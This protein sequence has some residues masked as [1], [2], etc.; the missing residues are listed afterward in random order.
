MLLSACSVF[1]TQT[2]T[3]Q[4]VKTL[5][6]IIV[7]Y[8]EPNRIQFSGKGAGAGMAL[9][10]TMGPMGMA[11][12]VAIDEGIAKDI[13]TVINQTGFS[14][15]TQLQQNL[16]QAGFNIAESNTPDAPKLHIKGYGFKSQPKDGEDYAIA[17][18][19]AELT[20]RDGSVKTL[21]YQGDIN[22]P[23]QAALLGQLKRDGEVSSY[24]FK[25]TIQ[26]L[27]KDVLQ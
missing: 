1:N 16:Q 11:I 27:I 3:E 26:L 17:W 19:K 21:E 14:V 18:I 20:N 22:N 15:Q 25:Q 2:N 9:M 12:G 4:K 7:S 23:E 5:K 10:S 24:L 6:P 8:A 13:R